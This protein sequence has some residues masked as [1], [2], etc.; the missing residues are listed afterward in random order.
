MMAG[1]N[2]VSGKLAARF[3]G[4]GILWRLRSLTGCILMSY[5]GLAVSTAAEANTAVEGTVA[6]V[7]PVSD[8]QLELQLI[9]ETNRAYVQVTNAG[10]NCPALF[11]RVRVTGGT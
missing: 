7:R 8:Q 6:F 4:F 9:L 11:S 1:W 3:A 5:V 10:G 2:I